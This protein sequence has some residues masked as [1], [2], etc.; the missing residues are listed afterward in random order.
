[1]YSEKIFI[2]THLDHAFFMNR[3]YNTSFILLNYRSF[4]FKSIIH[5]IMNDEDIFIKK[6]MVCS[7]KKTKKKYTNALL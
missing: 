4:F 1:M 2:Q 3:I 6:S 5:C 7:Q